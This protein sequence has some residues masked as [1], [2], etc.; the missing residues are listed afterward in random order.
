MRCLEFGSLNLR[1][2]DFESNASI[3][4]LFF[5][6]NCE[7]GSTAWE[8][9]AIFPVQLVADGVDCSEVEQAVD[10]GVGGG[11]KP[12]ITA[13]SDLGRETLLFF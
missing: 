6:L 10:G 12:D 9:A 3:D 5:F 4:F 7:W 11:G 2:R 1:S 13:F 8:Q